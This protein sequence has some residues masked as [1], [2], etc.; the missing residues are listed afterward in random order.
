M[1]S[2]WGRHGLI[3]NDSEAMGPGRVLNAS[4]ASGLPSKKSQMPAEAPKSQTTVV[5]R[6]YII[7]PLTPYSQGCLRIL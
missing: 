3:L 5:H 6:F 7:G 1:F 4:W 2:E